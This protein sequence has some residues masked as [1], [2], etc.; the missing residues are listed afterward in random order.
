MASDEYGG[1]PMNIAGQPVCVWAFA[2]NDSHPSPE[3]EGE[4]VRDIVVDVG[5]KGTSRT[6]HINDPCGKITVRQGTATVPGT[7]CVSVTE[8]GRDLLRQKPEFL[9]IYMIFI[10]VMERVE[11]FYLAPIFPGHLSFFFSP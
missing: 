2:C 9:P 10:R 3:G 8:L 4:A 7:H 11:P 5:K 6:P 1:S